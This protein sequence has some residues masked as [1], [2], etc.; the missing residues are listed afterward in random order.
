MPS[1][2]GG[3]L[4]AAAVEAGKI[5]LGTA[6]A[7]AAGAVAGYA[8]AGYVSMSG[9]CMAGLVLTSAGLAGTAGFEFLTRNYG[10]QTTPRR[11]APIGV[12]AA[13]V[14]SVIALHQS[15]TL[16]GQVVPR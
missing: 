10:D 4:G 16:A 5:V 9:W 3:I 11:L 13:A 1:I 12:A 7:A 6:T 15:F 2:A 8:W 14:A